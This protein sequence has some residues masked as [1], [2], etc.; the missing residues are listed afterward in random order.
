[1]RLTA[2]NMLASHTGTAPVTVLG[3]AD[4][5]SLVRIRETLAA[6]P[7]GPKLTYSHL[8]I[9]L[10]AT[11]L[12]RHPEMNAANVEDGVKIYD[13]INIGMATTL[14]DGNLVVPVIRNANLLTLDEIAAKA[15]E[16]AERVRAEKIRLEDVQ[17]GT[18]TFSNGGMFP[19]T[20]WITPLL[21]P[22]QVAILATGA[23][24]EK[25]L[26]RQGVVESRMTLG[27]SLTFEHRALNGFAASHFMQ[28]LA[29]MIAEPQQ[30]LGLTKL[31][32]T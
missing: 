19:S 25:V 9:R 32:G 13:E 20:R 31:P 17:C 21:N 11:A 26:L 2:R 3:E 14:P 7:A 16:L 12:V 24:Q 18:F 1:M 29:D 22:P 15:I 30:W 23:I 10:I 4:A 5:T 8:L 6:R 28:I 27:L